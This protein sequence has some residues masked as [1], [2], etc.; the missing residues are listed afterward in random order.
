MAQSFV[1]RLPERDADIVRV[2]HTC[3]AQR[4]A[5]RI[6]LIDIG[7]VRWM[8]GPLIEAGVATTED[9]FGFSVHD[10]VRH[11]LPDHI[12]YV[13]KRDKIAILL[14]FLSNVVDFLWCLE[15]RFRKADAIK[16]GL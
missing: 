3:R 9:S 11:V 7:K 13:S 10:L 2:L 1:K 14:R 15:G 6:R 12:G 8:L 5:V 4:L 16:I